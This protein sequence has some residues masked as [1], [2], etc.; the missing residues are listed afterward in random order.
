MQ[1]DL[2]TVDE[3]QRRQNTPYKYILLIISVFSRYA[4]FVLLRTKRVIE[5][6]KAIENI[7]DQDC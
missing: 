6:A 2:L 1:V 7:L 3:I 4:Y 5:V